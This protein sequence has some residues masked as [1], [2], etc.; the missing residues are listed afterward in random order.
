MF[1]LKL[2]DAFPNASNEFENA[3]S[4]FNVAVYGVPKTKDI[5]GQ[6]NPWIEG[7]LGQSKRNIF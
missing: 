5:P 7:G 6:K 3:E 2:S 1:D 4:P